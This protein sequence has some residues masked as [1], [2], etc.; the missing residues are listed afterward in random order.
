MEAASCAAPRNRI[1]ADTPDL[2]GR[3]CPR[4]H[5][6][7]FLILAVDHSPNPLAVNR[8]VRP[9][10]FSSAVLRVCHH[11]KRGVDRT[12]NTEPNTRVGSIPRCF[13]VTIDAWMRI[14]FRTDRSFIGSRR[15]IVHFVAGTKRKAAPARF[16]GI[17]A[18][19]PSRSGRIYRMPA[20]RLVRR[21]SLPEH[22]SATQRHNT[23]HDD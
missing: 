23:E 2:A 7:H 16:L 17:R 10:R 12:D 9:P 18:F 20:Y 5:A 4:P 14:V 8:C 6:N 22:R 15:R 21:S 11:S 13:S 3:F 1:V 19:D